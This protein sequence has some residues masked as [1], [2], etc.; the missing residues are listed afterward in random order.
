MTR[1]RLGFRGV[2]VV[3]LGVAACGSSNTP[4]PVPATIVVA[5]DTVRLVQGG[6]QQLDATVRDADGNAISGT[7]TWTGGTVATVSATGL[8]TSIAAGQGTV[9]ATAGTI[10]TNMPVVITGH[11]AG[12]LGPRLPLTNRPFGIAVGADS[13]LLATQLDGGTVGKGRTNLASFPGIHR[14]RQYSDR[15]HAS[16][17]TA[18]KAMSP[19]RARTMWECS[20]WRL[21]PSP[22]ASPF[23]ATLP[24]SPRHRLHRLRHGQRR[25]CV[26]RQHGDPADHRS[27]G[28][29]DSTRMASLGPP[30]ARGST[31]RT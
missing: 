31:S 1:F 7:I 9:T 2:M 30:T 26:R 16:R 18:W 29:R 22:P 4:N 8:L 3:V 21:E 5:P 25:Q 13:V 12:V 17:P 20:R 28:G 15:R 14:R 19:I 23:R 11:P 10:S 6:T 27:R 24:C